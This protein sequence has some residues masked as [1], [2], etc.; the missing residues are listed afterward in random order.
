[1][2]GVLSIRKLA[3]TLFVIL[4]PELLKLTFRKCKGFGCVRITS[5][6]VT[7]AKLSVSLLFVIYAQCTSYRR[8]NLW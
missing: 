7:R 8:T 4:T 2:V 6:V 5:V 3:T 1:M